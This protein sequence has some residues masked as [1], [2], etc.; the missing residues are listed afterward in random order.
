MKKAWTAIEPIAL[1]LVGTVVVLL[2][3]LGCSVAIVIALLFPRFITA[4]RPGKLGMEDVMG[5][6]LR[7]SAICGLTMALLLAVS[8]ALFGNPWAR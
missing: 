3:F 7:L 6:F 8:W 4:S 5:S 2:S 1:P